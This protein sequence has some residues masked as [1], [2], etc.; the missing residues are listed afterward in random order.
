[1][2]ISAA[3]ATSPTPI[4]SATRRRCGCSC[5]TYWTGCRVRA[6]AQTFDHLRHGTTT[7]F[8]ALQVATGKVADACTD[9]PPPEFLAFL[10]Q[11]ADS[12]RRR[13]HVV[14]DNLATHKHPAVRAWLERH[15]R[16]RLHYTR[17]SGS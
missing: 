2:H 1:M 6:A 10:K 15:P 7:L 3:S 13:L 8:A 4:R 5:G 9:R 11:V 17:T 16:V 12:P 14:V